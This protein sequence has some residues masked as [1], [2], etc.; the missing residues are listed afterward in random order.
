MHIANPFYAVGIQSRQ[1]RVQTSSYNVLDLFSGIGGF[2]VGLDRAGMNTVA[3]CEIDGFCRRIL[4]RH[5]PQVPAY[6]DIKQ[7][8]TRRLSPTSRS[9]MPTAP[10]S[11]GTKRRA[12]V[13]RI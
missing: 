3:F 13:R 1:R 7:L 11:P 6:P 4:K 12:S 9:S 8:T 10:K 5:W 2:S